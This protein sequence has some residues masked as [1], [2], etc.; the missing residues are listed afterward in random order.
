V[1]YSVASSRGSSHPATA[2]TASTASETVLCSGIS[3]QDIGHPL[4][5][6][7]A[8]NV[9]GAPAVGSNTQ[10]GSAAQPPTAS[11]APSVFGAPAAANNKQGGGAGQPPIASAAP[12]VFGGAKVAPVTS[13]FT[14]GNTN[15]PSVF[16]APKTEGATALG[17]A[18]APATFSFGAAASSPS[19]FTFGSSPASSGA[20]LKAEVPP[21]SEKKSAAGGFSFGSPLK[22]EVPGVGPSQK[23]G[24]FTF[25]NSSAFGASSSPQVSSGIGGG[26]SAKLKSPKEYISAL[27]LD[28]DT[29]EEEVQD[30]ISDAL[31]AW[32]AVVGSAD[33][34]VDVSHLVGNIWERQ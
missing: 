4:I 33:K 12:S 34:V 26:A 13:S 8:P 27:G 28:D 11:A 5:A 25:G 20:A 7:A 3:K 21:S 32:V 23:P 9:F 1:S 19:G 15:A 14:F 29:E 6:S 17:D 2:C 22:A 10:G 18:K 30:C 24:G 31:Q 16:G